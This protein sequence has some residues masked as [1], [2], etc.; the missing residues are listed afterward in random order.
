MTIKPFLD[1]SSIAIH[2]NPHHADDVFCIASIRLINPTITIVRTRDKETLDAADFRVD[3]GGKYDPSTGDYDHHQIDFDER[4]TNPNEAK[5]KKGPKMCAFGLIWKHH[6]KSIILAILD[7]L[8]KIS[9]KEWNVTDDI[10]DYIDQSIMDGLVACIGAMDNGEQRTYYLDTGSI[11][12]PTVIKFIQNYNPC[13]WMEGIDYDKFFF[14]AVDMATNY[15]EREVI[16]L[17]GQVQ[18][19]D[20]VL[21]A[22]EK[23]EDGYMVLD[24]YL[25]WGPIFTRFPFDTKDIK[26]VIYP[27]IDG[28]WMFQ[29][30]YIKMIVDKDRFLIDLHNG[31]KRKQRYQTPSNLCGKNEDE[32]KEITGINDVIFIHASGGF[33]GSAKTVEAAKSIAKYIVEHQE[34]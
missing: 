18:A 28:N 9:G 17:Y 22:V 26:F 16:K 5:H 19:V 25:P 30:P 20:P 27:T 7:K 15:L 6:S 1:N 21:E 23:A 13:T 14:R 3:V 34:Y 4:H 2:P 29:S 12:M 32:I 8:N 33:V 11:R 24:Q 31:E 10:L